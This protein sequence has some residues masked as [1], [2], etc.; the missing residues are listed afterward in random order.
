VKK[1][2]EIFIQ[3]DLRSTEISFNERYLDRHVKRRIDAEF[4]KTLGNPEIPCAIAFRQALGNTWRTEYGNL[5]V[6][7]E[8][9]HALSMLVDKTAE[10]AGRC[11]EAIGYRVRRWRNN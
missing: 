9:H 2:K 5:Y 4:C 6:R 11:I 7:T 1:W 10:D 8:L 3:F